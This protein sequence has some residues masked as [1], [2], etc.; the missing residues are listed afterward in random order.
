ML[1][2]CEFAQNNNTPVELSPPVEG[3]A[4][5]SIDM[6]E[7][8]ENGQPMFPNLAKRVT[9][10]WMWEVTPQRKDTL[11]E[12][13]LTTQQEGEAERVANLARY[14]QQGYAFDPQSRDNPNGRDNSEDVDDTED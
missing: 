10:Q 8:M 2:N 13:R 1:S 12:Q 9:P 3:F 6:R 11:R 4:M 7:T 14:I 5:F